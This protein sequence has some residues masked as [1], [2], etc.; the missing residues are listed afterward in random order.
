M[1]SRSRLARRLAAETHDQEAARDAARNLD[2][3]V[4]DRL[5]RVTGGDFERSPVLSYTPEVAADDQIDSLWLFSWGFRID[6]G[7]GVAPVELADPPPPMEAL[8]P[9]PVNRAI[10]EEAAEL[11]QRHPV[12]IIAQWE[13]AR[14]LDRLGVPDVISVEPLRTADGEIT[15]LSTPGV[16]EEGR[17]LATAAGV[18]PGRA[19]IITFDWLAVGSLLAAGQLGLDAV[20]PESIQ[21]P[22]EHDPESGQLWTRSLEAWLPVDLL[23][24]SYFAE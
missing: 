8:R 12:P 15:Y 19:G 18:V 9:G 3:G 7:S 20:V 23:G 17:R 13:V 2:Q 14:E 24:R 5:I 4:L 21:L 11:V 1:D 6:P 16:I 22:A 10:A